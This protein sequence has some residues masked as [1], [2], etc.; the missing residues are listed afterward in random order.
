MARLSRAIFSDG[1]TTISN[2]FSRSS[3]RICASRF[4]STTLP[5]LGQTALRVATRRAWAVCGQVGVNDFAYFENLLCALDQKITASLPEGYG[6]TLLVFGF[7][8]S[9]LFYASNGNREHMICAMGE[10]IQKLRVADC[11]LR[12]HVSSHARREVD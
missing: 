1:R 12:I 11:E 5:I 3:P 8:N 9:D 6:Y 10:F 2:P 7:N 4:A